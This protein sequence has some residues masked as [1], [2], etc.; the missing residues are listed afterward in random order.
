MNDPWLDSLSE[1]WVSQPRSSSPHAHATTSTSRSV[2]SSARGS[3]AKHHSFLPRVRGRSASVS[4]ISHPKGRLGES[5]PGSDDY[6]GVLSERSFSEINIPFRPGGG[7]REVSSQNINAEKD[8]RGRSR[9]VSCSTTRTTAHYTMQ[10]KS[11]SSSP[12]KDRQSYHTPEWK[13]RLL[14]GR[15]GPADVTDL[16]SPMG[17]EKIFQPPKAGNATKA[18]GTRIP[19]LRDEMPS[20]PPNFIEPAKKYSISSLERNSRRNDLNM[21]SLDEELEQHSECDSNGVREDYSHSD[22]AAST[23]R[24]SQ[25]PG[26]TVSRSSSFNPIATSTW[27]T[28]PEKRPTIL[29][30]GEVGSGEKGDETLT[31][32]SSQGRGDEAQKAHIAKEGHD[33]TS[34]I[35]SS[36]DEVA[37][38]IS[39]IFI[40]RQNTADGRV[41]YAAVSPQ[42]Q[43]DYGPDH[44]DHIE[45]RREG[46]GFTEGQSESIAEE[47]SEETD[48]AARSP[49]VNIRRGSYKEDASFYRKKLSPPSSIRHYSRPEEIDQSPSQSELT[50]PRLTYTNERLPSA[51]SPPG[52][53]QTPTQIREARDAKSQSKSGSPLKLFGN[54]DTFTNDKLL[55]R[56]SQMENSFNDDYQNQNDAV[57]YSS[58]ES[59]NPERQL[60]RDSPVPGIDLST[61][62]LDDGAE[63]GEEESLYDEDAENRPP[64]PELRPDQQTQFQFQR[65]PAVLE[66]ETVNRQLIRRFTKTKETRELIRN[67]SEEVLKSRKGST[68]YLRD[69]N[70]SVRRRLSDSK[71]RAELKSRSGENDGFHGPLSP[72]KDRTPKRRRTLPKEDLENDS[73]VTSSE[74]KDVTKK[75]NPVIGRKRKDARSDSG[76]QALDPQ[77]MAMRQILRPRTPTPSSDRSLRKASM[78]RKIINGGSPSP[79]RS[80]KV[81][82]Q[83][84][85]TVTVAEQRELNKTFDELRSLGINQKMMEG[86]RKGSVTTQDFLNEAQA[87]MDM[88]RSKGRPKS[89]LNSLQESD[90][91][92]AATEQDEGEDDMGYS[93]HEST[94]ES[95]TRP[96]SREGK[97]PV[98]PRLEVSNDPRINSYL[99][100]FATND[101]TEMNDMALSMNVN[102]LNDKSLVDDKGR[103][104]S[105]ATI[106]KGDINDV[107]SDP[108][109]IRILEG[110]EHQRKRKHSSSSVAHNYAEGTTEIPSSQDEGAATNL[111]S[112]S[113]TVNTGSTARSATVNAI[114]PDKVSHLIPERVGP[115]VFDPVQKLWVKKKSSETAQ[116]GSSSFVES[117]EDPFEDIPD[118][119][120][121]EIKELEAINSLRRRSVME[122]ALQGKGCAN[123]MEGFVG[124]NSSRP[125]TSN[126]SDNPPPASS[127][128][129]QDSKLSASASTAVRTETRAT[130]YSSNGTVQQGKSQ[131][132]K[133]NVRTVAVEEAHIVKPRDGS[134]EAQDDVSLDGE[135]PEPVHRLTTDQNVAFSSPLSSLSRRHRQRNP[136]M[137]APEIWVDASQVELE[138]SGFNH[139]TEAAHFLRNSQRHN[140]RRVTIDA[141]S[142]MRHKAN[143]RRV[144]FGG[145]SFSVRPVSRIDEYDEDDSFSMIA[146][147]EKKR[148]ISLVNLTPLPLRD[149]P[150]TSMPPPSTGRRIDVSFHLSPLP[151]FSINQVDESLALEVSHITKRGG[152]TSL[153]AV[154]GR[155]ELAIQEL[156][157]NITDVEPY[158]PYWEMIQKLDLQ[159]K[160]LVT[161]HMLRDFCERVEEINLSDNQLGQLSGAPVS[162]RDLQIRNNC[163]SSLTAWGHLSNLQYLDI[164]GNNVD[165]LLGEPFDRGVVYD[166]NKISG[167]RSL[168]HLRELVADDNAITS[169]EGIHQLDGLLSLRV[170][171]NCLT[172]IDFEGSSLK[173]LSEL[174]LQGNQISTVKNLNALSVVVNLNLGKL[175]SPVPSCHVSVG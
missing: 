13:K 41:D 98:Q 63:G 97:A 88:I 141:A 36:L 174:D 21:E 154:E 69:F 75:M 125:Q 32:S 124:Q 143:A 67:V 54:Y 14:G 126:S 26:K 87:V 73:L 46:N 11:I 168:V 150:S 55:R 3:V 7:N 60:Y 15:N 76:D 53:P 62:K 29:N 106:G 140:S 130:S 128:A 74:A 72:V 66:Q 162:L 116:Q 99:R 8:E 61:R 33:Q 166:A 79:R 22:V 23:T 117:E 144:S 81:H 121:D 38:G 42:K 137:G 132:T 153:R 50:L 4:S 118:L 173:R 86:S 58:D 64:L 135:S 148:E 96:P 95:F 43:T 160:G 108:P 102:A 165:N 56:M 12:Q 17:L 52:N 27:R 163:L 104:P 109:N 159:G 139:V 157:K 6:S 45:S 113:N 83:T 10:K 156:V 111:S 1:D 149:L 28:E 147:D 25:Q 138:D 164:S 71:D 146:R 122:R 91:E 133:A 65:T 48:W 94:L 5:K 89:G 78:A 59:F 37:E 142:S 107:E 131:D 172:E 93:E 85:Q 129:R 112:G 152:L 19:I 35:D 16:F 127:S 31:T 105:N 158:E 82:N 151:D 110:F 103:A 77:L 40:S 70:P 9:M 39:P 123:G 24:P 51:P 145:R 84:K 30:M 34:L 134:D 171:R 155:F 68:N 114:A 49:F 57:D 100:K 20:S 161:I 175:D 2:A 115:M 120:V 136:E 92:N 167:F 119:T 90:S 47:S 101:E 80:S 18:R 170:R 169:L 44:N